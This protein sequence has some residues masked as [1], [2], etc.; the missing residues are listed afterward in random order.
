MGPV[1]DFHSANKHLRPDPREMVP[2]KFLILS[3]IISY[4]IMKK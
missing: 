3:L 4:A 2:V 1:L